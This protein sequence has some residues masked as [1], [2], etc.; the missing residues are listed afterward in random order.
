MRTLKLA[1][2]YFALVFGA[3]FVLGIV[4]VVWLVPRWGERFAELAEMPLMLAV[5]VLAA[6][7]LVRRAAPRRAPA[8]LGVG[9]TAV[10]L[11]LL[12]ELALAVA[13]QLRSLADYV[14]G[15]DPV[16]GSA[17]LAMLLLMA[18][19]PWLIARRAV[20]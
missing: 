18:L 15:R 6:R 20:G 11:L 9:F 4:R 3:G 1:A 13:L 14:A 16:S 17:Y 2:A 7:A 12:A 19:M 8:W 5:I 10:G